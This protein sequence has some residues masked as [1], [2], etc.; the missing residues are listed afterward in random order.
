MPGAFNPSQKSKEI[1]SDFEPKTVP[2]KSLD[3]KLI[4]QGEN[5]E[6][7][8]LLCNTIQRGATRSN[9]RDNFISQEGRKVFGV[10]WD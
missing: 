7:P 3:M 4:F 5:N 6:K 2:E 8:S 9:V 1:T 10:N